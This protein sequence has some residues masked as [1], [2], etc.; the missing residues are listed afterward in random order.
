MEKIEFT[1]REASEEYKKL[2]GVEPH[3]VTQA[4]LENPLAFSTYSLCKNAK[5]KAAWLSKILN[6]KVVVI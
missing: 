6:L 1:I 2:H 3:L 5:E 4:Q